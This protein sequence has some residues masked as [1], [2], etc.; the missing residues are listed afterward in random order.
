MGKVQQVGFNFFYDVFPYIVTV[1]GSSFRN[2]VASFVSLVGAGLR[3]VKT[4]FYQ[5]LLFHGLLTLLVSRCLYTCEIGSG[6][7][8]KSV[9]ITLAGTLILSQRLSLR[10]RVIGALLRL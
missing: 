1:G 2:I 4:T 5:K 9:T 8:R 10:T 3:T 6:T 7:T